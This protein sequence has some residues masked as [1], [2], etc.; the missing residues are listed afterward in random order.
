MKSTEYKITEVIDNDNLFELGSLQYTVPVDEFTM[1][2]CGTSSTDKI[3][4][5]CKDCTVSCS[6]LGVTDATEL[7]ISIL[8]AFLTVVFKGKNGIF[9]IHN[10]YALSRWEGYPQVVNLEDFEYCNIYTF[11]QQYVQGDINSVKNYGEHL[12]FFSVG[13]DSGINYEISGDIAV[14][15]RFDIT[16]LRLKNLH[17]VTGSVESLDNLPLD[18]LAIYNTQVTG[19]IS[20]WANKVKS[21]QGTKVTTIQAS[22]SN[23]TV[24]DGI[25]K[26]QFYIHFTE[27]QN[28]IISNTQ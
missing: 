16:T 13:P 5:T 14:F 21:I 7:E 1:V 15:N 23:I 20:V 19:D 10:K 6:Y 3:K 18:L 27:G 25:N 12:N 22:N 4:I 28:P 17:N 2:L 11:S 24:P 26:T 8:D 9:T